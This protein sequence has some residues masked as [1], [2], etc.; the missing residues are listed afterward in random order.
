MKK[1]IFALL[2]SALL[3]S[4]NSS[5]FDFGDFVEGVNEAEKTKTTAETTKTATSN[6]SVI[7]QIAEKE[8]KRITEDIEKSIQK[9]LDAYKKMADK[10][11]GKI[12][13]LVK[14]ELGNIETMLKNVTKQVKFF[15]DIKA[16]IVG[17]IRLAAIIGT[18][19]VSGLVFLILMVFVLWFRVQRLEKKC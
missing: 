11:V 12:E 15:E 9:Q 13:D 6:G 3:L 8:I 19:L 10:E 7:E 14:S 4:T 18:I 17:Y 2:A 5:A 16:R 1:F